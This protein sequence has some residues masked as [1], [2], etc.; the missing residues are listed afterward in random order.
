MKTGLERI[1]DKA[2]SD[3]NFTFTS[4]AHHISQPLIWDHLKR[5]P[6]RTAMGVDGFNLEDTKETF[7]TWS[8]KAIEQI[9]NRAYAAPPVKR[10]HIPKP[11]KAAKR[12]IGIP[13]IADRAVQGATA[14][15]L[16]AIYE[17]SRKS[18]S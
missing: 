3:K 13:S 16:N 12:P 14:K 8:S 6:K 10:V 9:H 1:A 18:C 17:H 4:L 11:G 15:M 7:N 2:Q 5:I